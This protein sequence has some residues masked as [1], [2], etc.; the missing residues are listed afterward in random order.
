[1]DTSRIAAEELFAAFPHWRSLARNETSEGGDSYVVI[2]VQAPNEANVEHGLSID[3]SNDEVTVE[4]DCYHAHFN[5]WTSDGEHSGTQTAIEFIK[6]I[7]SERIAVISWWF[8]D[9]WRGSAH[10]QAGA[11]PETSVWGADGA[12][13]RVRIRSWK[14]SLNADSSA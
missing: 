11:S 4:F 9:E 5:D 7:L 12:I 6:Q 8:N 13:N 2:E 10:F 3:T 14:G 1:M